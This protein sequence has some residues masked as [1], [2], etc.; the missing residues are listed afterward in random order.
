M[1]CMDL[2]AP[3]V[4]EII[5]GSVREERESHLKKQMEEKGVDPAS[6]N[7]YMD[8][9]RY[10]SVPHGG[11]GLGFERFLQFSTGAPSI[12]DVTPMPRYYKHCKN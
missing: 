12:R 10:G 5:G 3:G 4:G 6:Y 1:E 2:L 11:F 8:L 7:W 9:R